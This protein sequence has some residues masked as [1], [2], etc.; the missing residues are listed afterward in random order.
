MK[1]LTRS[2]V[3][4]LMGGNDVPSQSCRATCG[5]GG[6]VAVYCPSGN[7]C[8]YPPNGVGCLITGQY[9]YCPNA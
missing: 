4:K 1:K 9:A 3:K 5:E 8:V 7:A 6:W 2:E